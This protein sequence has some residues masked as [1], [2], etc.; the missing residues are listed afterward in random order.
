MLDNKGG[1][2]DNDNIE[3][4]NIMELFIRT[5]IL[6]RTFPQQAMIYDPDVN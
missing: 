2:L 1:I 6:R 3:L 4:L 5:T